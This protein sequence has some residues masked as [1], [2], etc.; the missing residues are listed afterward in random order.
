M[1]FFYLLLSERCVI[2]LCQ[3][4]H[5]SVPKTHYSNPNDVTI[6]AQSAISSTS[7]QTMCNSSIPRMSFFYSKSLSLFYSKDVSSITRITV[8]FPNDVSVFIREKPQLPVMKTRLS[9]MLNKSHWC[10]ITPK[11]TNSVVFHFFVFRTV[12]YVLFIRS[13]VIR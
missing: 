3:R 11:L 12:F 13:I 2:V 6:L 7:I 10:I 1:P 8:F 5:S 9:S 4:G